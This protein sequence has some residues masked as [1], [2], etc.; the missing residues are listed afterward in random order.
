MSIDYWIYAAIL[1]VRDTC[2]Q[3]TEL[4]PLMRRG[5]QITIPG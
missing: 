1:Q 5:L 3:S 2:L 4:L